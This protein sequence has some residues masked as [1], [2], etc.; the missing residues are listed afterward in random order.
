MFLDI[1]ESLGIDHSDTKTAIYY[2]RGA[3]LCD[4][5]L[6]AIKCG[7]ADMSAG[8]CDTADSSRIWFTY[9]GSIGIK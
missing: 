7:I 8:S 5:E 9:C 6:G 1:L 2:D 3:V 4:Y